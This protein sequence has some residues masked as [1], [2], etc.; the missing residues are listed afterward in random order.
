M[1]AESVGSEAG[2]SGLDSSFTTYCLCGSQQGYL[3]SPVCLYF[4][5][6]NKANNGSFLLDYREG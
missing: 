6:H 5:M 3:I 1:V 4:Y 2:L